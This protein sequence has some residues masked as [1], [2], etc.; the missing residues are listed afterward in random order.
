VP[1]IEHDLGLANAAAGLLT[2]IPLVGMGLCTLA[3]PRL[4]RRI[5]AGRAVSLSLAALA[6]AGFLRALA[7]DLA[8]LIALTVVVG[9]GTGLAGAMLPVFVK[10]HFPTSGALATGVYTTSIQV[11]AT[12]AA[13]AAAPLAILTGSWRGAL[14][15]MSLAGG[16]ALA[17]WM[18]LTRWHGEA[19]A[20]SAAPP[21]VRWRSPMAWWLALVFWLTALPFYGLTS[22]LAAAYVARGWSAVEAGSLVAVLGLAGLPGTLLVAMLADRVGSRRGF[23]VG[24]A[25]LFIIAATALIVAPGLAWVAAAL[26]GATLGGQFTLSL[27]LP[28]DVSHDPAEASGT[29]GLVLFVGYLLTAATPV[30]L[31]W[32]ADAT[33]D[34]SAS[35]WVVVIAEIALVSVCLP[36]SAARLAAARRAPV[37]AS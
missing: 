7:P 17:G 3:A 26:A 10:E 18:L 29:I 33:H 1:G 35:L 5:G 14:A 32:I 13:A 21:A 31:G 36:L 6:V 28:L 37:A 34:V 4:V 22:W 23:L 9:L 8:T 16:A 12:A 25:A 19:A 20:P 30:G 24:T 15:G 2:T 11:G 27:T